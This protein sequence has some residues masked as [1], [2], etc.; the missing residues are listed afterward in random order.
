VLIIDDEKVFRETLVEMIRMT[1][2]SAKLC[3]SASEGIAVLGNMGNHFRLSSL[4]SQCLECQGLKL[5]PLL[6][7]INPEMKIL[8]TSG[9]GSDPRDRSLLRDGVDGFF[10]NPYNPRKT[11]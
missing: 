4:T 9:Y 10:Q 5:N 7:K 1:A 8:L 6:K 11:V 3:P 2:L